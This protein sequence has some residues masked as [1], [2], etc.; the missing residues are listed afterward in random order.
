MRPVRA[1][2]PL[3]VCELALQCILLGLGD[4]G[5][6]LVRLAV[7]VV[8]AIDAPC[9]S[10]RLSLRDPVLALVLDHVTHYPVARARLC[11]AHAAA[12]A[13]ATLATT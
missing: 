9:E 13:P 11:P 6:H 5:M 8:E 4:A 10:S 1:Q 12:R 2:L 3:K 7:T